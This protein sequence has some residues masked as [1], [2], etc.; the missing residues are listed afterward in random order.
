MI[1]FKL[2]LVDGCPPPTRVL[3]WLSQGSG[4]IKQEGTKN[5]IIIFKEQ[6]HHSLLIIVN[7]WRKEVKNVKK[8]IRN[9]ET[10][11]LFEASNFEV[12]WQQPALV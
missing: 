1:T 3:C 9:A 8:L 6:L 2:H 7:K 4:F 10:L 11:S 12:P 5:W